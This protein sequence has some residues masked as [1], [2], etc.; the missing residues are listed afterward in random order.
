MRAPR[1]LPD[2]NFQHRPLPMKKSFVIFVCSAFGFCGTP[3]FSALAPAP[4]F[5]PADQAW[6]T[7]QSPVPTLTPP[8]RA[9]RESVDPDAIKASAA[10][11]A[12]AF[13]VQ[14]NQAKVFQ[15]QFPEHGKAGEA[16]L[17]E[18][19]ALVSAVQ[20]GDATVEGRLASAVQALRT[21][22][23]VPGAIRVQ[24]VASYEFS[25]QTRGLKKTLPERLKAIEQVAR[26]L[27]RD[28]P[29]QPQGFESLLNVAITDRDDTNAKKIAQ[30][31][32]GMP[33]PAT[34]K[35]EARKLLDRLALVGKPFEAELTGANETAVKAALQPRQP[36]VVYTWTA[37]NPGSL[38]LAAELKKRGLA[39]N[40]I[41][42]NLD[43]NPVA[44][45]A[46]AQ[47]E[48]LIGTAV[49]DSR[50]KEGALAQRLKVRGG[51]EVFLVDAQG[52]IRDVRA[53][54][55]LSNALK[56]VGL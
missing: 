42:L 4:A 53:Q 22:S 33:A 7:L 9:A 20:L 19:R 3:S 56:R 30:E 18:V 45:V 47:S 13:L 28:F 44:A 17:V 38:A 8:T 50:G 40:I 54:A 25:R 12:T 24:G 27:A 49:Y 2:G 34:S 35:N 29:D 55:D 51:A 48:G 6:M 37:G 52:V 43:T 21:D 16:K 39:A 31:L 26:D 41:A 15:T 32:L 1:L 46:V 10:Q 23:T 14:A 11:R 5:S 36:T